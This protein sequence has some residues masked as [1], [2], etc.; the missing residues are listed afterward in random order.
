MGRRLSETEIQ[1]RLPVWD[2]IADLYLDNVVDARVIDSIAR[3]LA[4]SPFS[5]DELEAI[6]RYE[7][8]PVVHGNLKTTAGEWAGWG[9]EW[10]REHMV[11]HVA[12]SGRFSRWW[13]DTRPGRWWMTADTRDD[14]QRVMRSVVDKR[15]RGE[16]AAAPAS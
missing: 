14:W 2:A 6:Y 11:P 7:V 12:R 10:L 15:A 13:A 4:A 8:A 1:A 9:H 5:V 3:T 16:T